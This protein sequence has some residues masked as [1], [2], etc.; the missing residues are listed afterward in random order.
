MS[1]TA[2]L[3]TSKLE[4][5]IRSQPPSKWYNN[6]KNAWLLYIAS[7]W[8]CRNWQENNW[9]EACPSA[10]ANINNETDFMRIKVKDKQKMVT[11]IKITC[12]GVFIQTNSYRIR[13][14]TTSAT[15]SD[16][17]NNTNRR[18]NNNNS[19]ISNNGFCG[20]GGGGSAGGGGRG[21]NNNHNA[22]YIST[23]STSVSS[24]ASL[25]AV[26]S[27]VSTLPS[28]RLTNRI[29]IGTTSS[30]TS[31][32]CPKY[33]RND[34]STFFGRITRTDSKAQL[35]RA[36]HAGKCKT[37]GGTGNG[38]AT[39]RRRNTF[40]N[41]LIE[42]KE[43]LFRRL[44]SPMPMNNGQYILWSR[45]SNA[46]STFFQQHSLANVQSNQLF[47]PPPIR[48]DHNLSI[49]FNWF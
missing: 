26:L 31:N 28:S 6:N 15:V 9:R 1:G 32:L 5:V 18:I 25:P 48:R 43:N 21:T 34:P 46:L 8:M 44:S 11:T 4:Y 12:D 38:C 10:N 36:E 41:Y 16:R 23:D 33:G 49:L 14:T 35:I 2:T 13:T 37:G 7:H 47:A 20:G 22:F 45:Y 30:S 19:A 3:H 17:N 29:L 24:P 27:S 40:K 42:C 39:V